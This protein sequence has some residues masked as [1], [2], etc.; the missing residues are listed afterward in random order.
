MAS[1][2]EKTSNLADAIANL[3]EDW[4]ARGCPAHELNE[5]YKACKTD[6]DII[7]VNRVAFKWTARAASKIHF[8]NK[9]MASGLP[10]L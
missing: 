1:S 7:S 2:D 3:G 6:Q 5:A 10:T 9:Y 8:D 4:K